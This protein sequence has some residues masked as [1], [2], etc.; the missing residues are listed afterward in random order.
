VCPQGPPTLKNT[1]YGGLTV[2]SASNTG[3]CLWNELRPFF[4]NINVARVNR[5][6]VIGLVR[7]GV[8]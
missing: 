6:L 1:N 8:S 7:V 3:S 5:G 2:L 4:L